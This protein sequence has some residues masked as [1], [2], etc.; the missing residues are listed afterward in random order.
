[1]QDEA[2]KQLKVAPKR[3]EPAAQVLFDVQMSCGFAIGGS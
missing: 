3:S 2:M 1:M